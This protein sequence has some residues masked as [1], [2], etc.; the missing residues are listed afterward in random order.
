MAYVKRSDW[1]LDTH[2]EVD[3]RQDGACR[4]YN[5][6][7][8]T[9]A[10][11]D[12]DPAGWAAYVCL[13]CPV[14]RECATWAAEN[15]SLCAG[16]IYG[17]TYYVTTSKAARADIRPGRF[18]PVPRQPPDIRDLLTE[19]FGTVGTLERERVRGRRSA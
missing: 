4:D 6:D 1:G 3:W 9:P 13:G 17:G 14:R 11:A 10:A 2:R 15:P 18:Q 7:W 16:S 12:S 5:P 8:W 19:R